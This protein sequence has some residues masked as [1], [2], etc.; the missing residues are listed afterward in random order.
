ME[1][2]LRS[3]S[4]HVLSFALNYGSEL[5]GRSVLDVVNSQNLS[6]TEYVET[7]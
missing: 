1:A 7:S 6:I 2:M 4:K 3:N 5:P